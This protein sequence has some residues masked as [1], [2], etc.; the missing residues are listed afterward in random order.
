MRIRELKVKI[1][2]LAEEQKIIRREEFKARRSDIWHWRQHRGDADYC[3]RWGDKIEGTNS[4]TH[5]LC[6]AERSL[7]QHRVHD[8]RPEIRSAHIAY[9]L[10][11]GL[12]YDS[13]EKPKEGNEPNWKRVSKIVKSF[14]GNPKDYPVLCLEITV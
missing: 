1:K 5:S 6:D 3:P 14:G 8:V 13:I 7:R 12:N 9:G 10:M 11:R 4:T 2:S